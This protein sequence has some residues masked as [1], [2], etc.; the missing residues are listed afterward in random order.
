MIYYIFDIWSE[1]KNMENIL[2][3][4]RIKVIKLLSFRRLGKDI[5]QKKG[6][7]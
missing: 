6:I 2:K 4:L 7:N 1:R 5:I 3:R